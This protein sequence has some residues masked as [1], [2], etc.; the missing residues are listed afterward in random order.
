M[1]NTLGIKKSSISNYNVEWNGKEFDENEIRW[2]EIGYIPSK[3][4]PCRKTT[5]V[6]SRI[7]MP[8]R[9]QSSRPGEKRKLSEEKSI[10]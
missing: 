7:Y 8:K 10:R 2:K 5:N 4:F 3:V 1:V 6:K 9:N